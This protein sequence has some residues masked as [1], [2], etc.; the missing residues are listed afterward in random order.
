[1]ID[2]RDD[3][4]TRRR[5]GPPTDAIMGMAN[6]LIRKLG[7][8]GGATDDTQDDTGQGAEVDREPERLGRFEVERKLGAGAMG[9]VY[10]AHDPM[11]RRDVAIKVLAR[12]RSS[13]ISIAR[14]RREAQAMAQ[15][16]HPNVVE[17][18]AIGDH[19]GA[20]YIAME[21]V[22]G[23]T[24]AE[25]QSDQS[26]EAILGAYRQ[27]ARGLAALH[28]H[29]LLHR[30]FKPANAMMGDDGRVRV[31]DLGLVRELGTASSS[32]DASGG[33]SGPRLSSGSTT[34]SDAV[35][36]TPAYMS[37]EQFLGG[38]IGPAADQF[39][40]CVSLYEALYGHRPFKAKTMTQLVEA[41]AAQRIEPPPS[42]SGVPRRIHRALRRGLYSE[43]SQRHGS[44][45]TLLDALD[46]RRAAMRCAGGLAVAGLLAAVPLRGAVTEPSCAVGDRWKEIW[47]SE[48]QTDAE[49]G[50]ALRFIETEARGYDQKIAEVCERG[51]S[52]GDE[53]CFSELL[54]RF[55]AI[56]GLLEDLPEGL[57][58]DD[59]RREA[60]P[61]SICDDA[62][63]YLGRESEYVAVTADGNRVD[64]LALAGAYDAALEL[65][66]DVVRRAQ[67]LDRPTVLYEAFYQR[68]KVYARRHMLPE[69]EADFS[70][71]YEATLIAHAHNATSNTASSLVWVAQN[72]GDLDAAEHWLSVTASAHEALHGEP[73]TGPRYM[74]RK[75]ELR[76]LQSRYAEGQEVLEQALEGWRRFENPRE[77]A[78]VLG[79]LVEVHIRRSKPESALA[80]AQEAIE[81]MTAAHGDDEPQLGTHYLN[82]GSVQQLRGDHVASLA[83]FEQGVKR[84]VKAHGDEHYSTAVARCSKASALFLLDRL[85]EARTTVTTALANLPE[86]DVAAAQCLL[87]AAKA[88]VDSDA[89]RAMAD[90]NRAVVILEGELGHEHPDA[91]K[92]RADLAEIERS[93]SSGT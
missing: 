76:L 93:T 9:V 46:G 34:I 35:L 27:A 59:V 51:T 30:D 40:F 72:M 32:E 68:G 15:L 61:P 65:G 6:A 70:A 67:A 18:Y 58:P 22:Y 21:R 33:Y 14:A 49:E 17:V 66:H 41:I 31:L 87:V 12:D 19:D 60:I 25:W 75:G 10:A 39:S 63:H 26:P 13:E 83:A 36:G 54:T 3:N 2:Q 8:Q 82:L 74:M 71:A 90:A 62:E 84:R 80:A 88:N 78:T 89:A 48:R 53:A 56:V 37:P 4:P 50:G 28:A 11:L 47:T 92:A 5:P 43:P 7:E 79:M 73:P 91:V 77:I 85:D 81:V 24:L 16:S 42:K 44:M 20:L 55:S 52:P 86:D 57:D 69:A 64:T 23:K 45:T 1:M 29:G 38:N